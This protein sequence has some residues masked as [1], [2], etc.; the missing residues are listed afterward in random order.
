MLKLGWKDYS[1]LV[2]RQ[3][4]SSAANT[5]LTFDIVDAFQLSC[6]LKF[7][8][9]VYVRRHCELRVASFARVDCSVM[10]LCRA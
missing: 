4:V 2:Q 3:T 8:L 9:A 5:D 10:M 1:D 6:Y 7:L